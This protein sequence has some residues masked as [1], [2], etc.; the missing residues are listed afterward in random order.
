MRSSTAD[1]V[2]R[3]AAWC[4]SLRQLRET[5][6]A[7]EVSYTGELKR[8][9]GEA[10]RAGKV[11]WTGVPFDPE[12]V[13]GTTVTVTL[14]VRATGDRVTHRGSIAEVLGQLEDREI[15]SAVQDLTPP[16]DAGPPDGAGEP[17][18]HGRLAF[19]TRKARRH[20]HDDP[21]VTLTVTGDAAWT[22]QAATIVEGEL[23]ERQPRWSVVKQPGLAFIA[24]VVATAA[25][26][27]AVL[28]VVE[29]WPWLRWPAVAIATALGLTTFVPRVSDWLFPSF[30]VTEG[31]SRGTQV[32][33]LV[34]TVLFLDV[35]G[36]VLGN[37]LSG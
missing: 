10:H 5:F 24:S 25:V 33:G 26:V 16:I 12:D 32:L 2:R 36:G 34:A 35:F 20:V 28:V 27:G 19:V 9:I 37:H 17:L 18:P 1:R 7:L 6:E 30:Q 21:G 3:Q 29:P 22:A 13:G 8:L 14:H 31:R 15:I 11:P 23:R 4:G